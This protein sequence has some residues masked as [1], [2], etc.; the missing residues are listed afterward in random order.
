MTTIRDEILASMKMLGEQ[1]DVRFLGYNVRYG[2]KA[3]GSLNDV[4]EDKLVEMP[5]AENLMIG[6]AIGFSLD[7]FVPVVWVERMDFILCGM[8]ALVNHLNHLGAL[9]D[10][11]HNPGVIIRICVGNSRSPL[12]T[13]PTHTQNFYEAFLKLVRMPVYL[14]TKAKQVE[15]FYRW[16]IEG[17]R[18]GKSTIIIEQKDL[19][20]EP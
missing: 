12:F 10:S 6:A 7:G 5:L 15:A 16:A 9:S 13:G 2:G 11:L 8:D 14:I 3:G 20:N 19:Y 17:A 1:P 18:K 4:P